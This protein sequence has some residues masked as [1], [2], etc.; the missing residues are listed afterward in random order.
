MI[1]A[2]LGLQRAFDAGSRLQRRADRFRRFQTWR[3]SD[4][5]EGRF[6]RRRCSRSHVPPDPALDPLRDACQRNPGWNGRRRGLPRRGGLSRPERLSRVSAGEPATPDDN[7]LATTSYPV[8]AFDPNGAF[9]QQVIDSLDLTEDSLG[10][11]DDTV[12]GVTEGNCGRLRHHR[13]CQLLQPLQPVRFQLLRVRRHG[14]RERLYGDIILHVRRG[15][16]D[17]RHGHGRDRVGSAVRRSGHGHARPDVLR[18][19]L[20]SGDG[21]PVPELRSWTGRTANDLDDPGRSPWKRRFRRPARAARPEVAVRYFTNPNVISLIDCVARL[22]GPLRRPDRTDRR[23][24]DRGSPLCTV[25]EPTV[26]LNFFDED[27]NGVSQVGP[28]PC[29]SPCS[30]PPPPRSTS[31]WR[32]TAAP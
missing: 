5:L 6:L 20:G 1:R 32:P 30:T 4:V 10:C 21:A 9:A 2:R 12:D 13:P 3:M 17:L 29:P 25:V 15:N 11:L 19:L 18:P 27:E 28:G 22:L 7:V 31:R 23:R 14:Q 8:P 26:Q 16:R 24:T